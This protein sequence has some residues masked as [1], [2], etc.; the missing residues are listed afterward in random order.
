MLDSTRVING[1]YGYVY[2]DGTW[3][4]NIKSAEANVEITKEEI[5]RA[6]TRWTAHKVTGLSGTGTISGYKVTSE[7]VERIGKIADDSQGT[8]ITEL[9][10]KLEDPESYGAY[11]VRLKG[12]T[13]DKIPLMHF[14]VGAIV[15]E[16][17]PF[18]FTGYELLD[19]ITAE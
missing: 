8:F 12:V 9:I 10:L 19:K 18:N 1:T 4:T 7:F 17:L 13:F 16:E 3:L 14:E 15:E 6:G 5:K 2:H 11:R